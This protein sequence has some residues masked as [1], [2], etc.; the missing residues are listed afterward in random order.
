MSFS[1]LNKVSAPENMQKFLELAQLAVG[2]GQNVNNVFEIGNRFQNTNPMELCIRMIMDEPNSA[3]MVKERYIGAEYDLQ[4]MLAMPKDSLGWTYATILSTMGYDPEFYPHA[5]ENMTDGEYISFRTG[6]TH[7]IH[8]I[9]TG[10]SL[11]NF[12]ELGVISIAAGQTRFPSF[13]FVDLLSLMMSFF[14]SEQ[15]YNEA[16]SPPEQAQ[17]LKYKLELISQGLA[18]AKQA[19]PLFPIKWEEG[20]EKPLEQ[21]RTELNITPVKTGP[22]SWYSNPKLQEALQF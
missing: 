10:F 4:A 5:T 3:A 18:I 21:W 16:S 6:K 17:T 22:Y 1:Y 20:F 13:L 9:L 15:L 19:K 2:V 8:H 14:F 11:D 7:D 12:G